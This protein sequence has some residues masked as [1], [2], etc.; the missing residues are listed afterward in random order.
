[1]FFSN[2]TLMALAVGRE[3]TLEK[4][5]T[6]KKDHCKMKKNNGKMTSGPEHYFEAE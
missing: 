6:L 5:N 4:P 3:E 2:I 1:M